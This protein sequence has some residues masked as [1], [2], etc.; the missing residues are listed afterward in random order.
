VIGMR[1]PHNLSFAVFSGAALIVVFVGF[2]LFLVGVVLLGI[3]TLQFLRDGEWTQLSL[4]EGVGYLYHGLQ[5]WVN[6]PTD[7]LGLHRILSRIPCWIGIA[8]GLV[9]MWGGA[10]WKA[11]INRGDRHQA[12]V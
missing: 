4:L 7:W 11:A 10:Y 6:A 5:A 8:I 1:R 12:G 3:S 9:L 2:A